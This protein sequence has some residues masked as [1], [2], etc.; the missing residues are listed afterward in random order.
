MAVTAILVEDD[1]LLASALAKAL[2]SHGIEVLRD[3][4]NAEG[5]L[6]FV[7][8]RRPDVALI[9]LDLGPG[10]TGLDIAKA[11]RSAM[12]RIGLVILTSYVDPRLKGIDLPALPRGTKYLTKNDANDVTKVAEAL[13]KAANSPLI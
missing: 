12:P 6:S 10:P 7:E 13:L 8:Q 3:F 2:A 1:R 5:V 4:P 11:L 9:D